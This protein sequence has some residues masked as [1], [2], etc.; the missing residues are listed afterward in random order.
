MSRSLDD[1]IP[2]FREKVDA[3]LAA[4]GARGVTMR[5]YSTLRPPMDQARLWRQS[6]ASEEI[7]SNIARLER[8]GAT[9]LAGL[10]RGV[11]PQFGDP[12]TN[13]LPGSSWHQWGEA[14]DCF[15]V[16]DGAANWSTKQLVGGI[17]GYRVYAE[18]AEKLGLQP[19][20][21][22]QTF[23]DW[24]HVQLRREGGPLRLMSWAAIDTEMRSRFA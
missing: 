10:I 16:V 22:W 11:G 18:E 9:F 4:C 1:L 14:V 23:K 20:G 8:E 5:P 3:L 17:N 2:A 15:W 12:V 24:P 19:G 7:D 21:H 6:R 13:A